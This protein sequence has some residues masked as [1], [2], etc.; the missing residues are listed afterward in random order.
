MSNE[1]H[2]TVKQTKRRQKVKGH[3]DGWNYNGENG[4][5]RPGGGKKIN[6]RLTARDLLEQAEL[7]IGK[8]LAVSI[9]EG[10]RDTILDNDRKTRVIYEKMLLDKT[11]ST[12]LDVDVTATEDIVKEKRVAFRDAVKS[13]MLAQAD[14]T[15]N[16]ATAELTEQVIDHVRTIEN[17]GSN[18]ALN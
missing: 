3:K 1:E 14:K 5:A 4:G 18:R 2:T 17:K 16:A 9:L 8:P 7:V 6:H 10:Y 13:L 11:A 12:I 15:H